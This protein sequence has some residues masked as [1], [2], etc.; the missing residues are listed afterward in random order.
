[1]SSE[2]VAKQAVR[3]GAP[4]RKATF[5]VVKRGVFAPVNK[6]AVKFTR[7]LRGRKNLNLSK[8]DLLQISGNGASVWVY[9]PQNT[10][11]AVKF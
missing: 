6:R 3:K 8:E 10:L 5:K 7:A 11:K 2:T 4:V 1:M 9:T